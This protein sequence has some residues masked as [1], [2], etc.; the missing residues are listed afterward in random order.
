[1]KPMRV[2]PDTVATYGTV[3]ATGGTALASSSLPV[4]R[5]KSRENMM[6]L[7]VFWFVKHIKND[8]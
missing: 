7:N 4:L 2:R 5:V 1:M 6:Q 3:V 8:K